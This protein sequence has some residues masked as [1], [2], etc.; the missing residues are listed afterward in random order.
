MFFQLSKDK[1]LHSVL[2]KYDLDSET[3]ELVEN[4]ASAAMIKD[5][6]IKNIDATNIVVY[7]K[8]IEKAILKQKEDEDYGEFAG[9]TRY[10]SGKAREREQ[11]K[12]TLQAQTEQEQTEQESFKESD[13]FRE[14]TMLSAE[15]REKSKEETEHRR[16]Q[17]EIKFLVNAKEKV[18]DLIRNV[19][20]Q[21]N[22][23]PPAITGASAYR[24]ISKR[25][26]N[27]LIK[28]LRTMSTLPE[29]QKGTETNFIVN[30]FKQFSFNGEFPIY[31]KKMYKREKGERTIKNKVTSEINIFDLNNTYSALANSIIDNT[32]S[33]KEM[34][35]IEI[36]GMLHLRAFNSEAKALA[37]VGRIARDFSGFK[38][39]IAERDAKGYNV[40]FRRAVSSLNKTLQNIENHIKYLNNSNSSLKNTLEEFENV[41]DDYL[42]EYAE[43]LVADKA[44]ELAV[45]L[46]VFTVKAGSNE[47]PQYIRDLREEIKTLKENPEEQLDDL[48]MDLANQWVEVKEDYEK[49]YNKFN[50]KFMKN[51]I[52]EINLIKQTISSAEEIKDPSKELSKK[53]RQIRRP[54]RKLFSRINSLTKALDE[55]D[56]ETKEKW[57]EF[58]KEDSESLK[59][60]EADKPKKRKKGE[61]LASS[62]GYRIDRTMRI[63]MEVSEEQAKNKFTELGIDFKNVQNINVP[64]S[65]IEEMIQDISSDRADIDSDIRRRKKEDAEQEVVAEIP[66]DY[67]IPSWIEEDFDPERQMGGKKYKEG[68][69]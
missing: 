61:N 27:F 33:N 56:D 42:L 23:S 10:T 64:V 24:D 9:D 37:D 31:S 34:S 21:T 20:I 39:K 5:S 7:R 59:D 55:L 44:R 40:R 58:L 52:A 17:N 50:M 66:F 11:R 15:Q 18:N 46:K 28:V 49:I 8:L 13:T 53:I 6:L 2:L 67:D 30:R 62:V 14:S 25:D 26:S 47:M 63:L 16:A 12:E 68:F 45:S 65:E 69:E 43:D 51:L 19:R 54:I 48:R 4:Q 32:P 29:F 22:L 38:T 57:K 35:V 36:M 1:T 3:K 41:D 60:L